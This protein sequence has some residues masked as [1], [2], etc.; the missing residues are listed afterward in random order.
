M[1]E[2]HFFDLLNEKEDYNKLLYYITLTKIKISVNE[3]IEQMDKEISKI[4]AHVL[5]KS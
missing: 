1:E 3:I 5:E 2:D 4:A